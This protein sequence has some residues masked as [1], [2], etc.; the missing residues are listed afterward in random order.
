MAIPAPDI[1]FLQ[2]PSSSLLSTNLQPVHVARL[3]GGPPALAG[4]LILSARSAALA[5]A[6]AFPLSKLSAKNPRRPPSNLIILD[7]RPND[8]LDGHTLRWSW[9]N[10]L[11]C[12]HKL[13]PGEF[14]HDI[15]TDV[16]CGTPNAVHCSCNCL[17]LEEI[18]Q[19][20]TDG[21]VIVAKHLTRAKLI[22]IFAVLQ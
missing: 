9:E 19:D 21:G 14:V 8:G 17:Y 4:S 12:R 10:A 1:F 20:I 2:E 7:R 5:P 22:H 15:H 13:G 16:P 11:R 3:R 18:H 6:R